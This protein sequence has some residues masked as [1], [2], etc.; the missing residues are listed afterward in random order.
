MED[1]TLFTDVLSVV[2]LECPCYWAVGT[3]VILQGE[4]TRYLFAGKTTTQRYAIRK[5][6]FCFWEE[7]SSFQRQSCF[8][9]SVGNISPLIS[10]DW[11]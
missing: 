3:V 1:W 4:L 8:K 11:E 6:V 7:K 2:F 5:Y 9:T 10:A